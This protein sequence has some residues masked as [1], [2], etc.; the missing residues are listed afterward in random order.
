MYGQ[1]SMIR[2]MQGEGNGTPVLLPG[3]ILWTEEPGGLLSIGLQ[4]SDTTEQIN[5]QYDKH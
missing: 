5:H 2:Y 3:K 4:E 1:Y